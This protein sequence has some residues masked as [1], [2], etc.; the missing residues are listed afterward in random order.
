[1]DISQ[2]GANDRSHPDCCANGIAISNKCDSLT[3]F[4]SGDKEM[5]PGMNIFFSSRDPHS[6]IFTVEF[7]WT[8][9]FALINKWRCGGCFC[10][11]LLL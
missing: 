11:N 10:E 4:K 2:L 6:A 3:R 5:Y 1:M 9:T 8:F 7:L